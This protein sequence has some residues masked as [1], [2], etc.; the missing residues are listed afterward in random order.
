MG[1]SD[2]FGVKGK[3]LDKGKREKQFGREKFMVFFQICYNLTSLIN[4]T[5]LLDILL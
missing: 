3:K 5:G 2:R 1:V 4:Y